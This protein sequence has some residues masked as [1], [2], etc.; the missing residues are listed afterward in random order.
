MLTLTTL[1]E[2]K[3]ENWLATAIDELAADEDLDPE[4]ADYVEADQTYGNGQVVDFGNREYAIYKDYDEAEAAAVE[5]LTDM[6]ES[7]PGVVEGISKNFL[8]S[9][10]SMSP[11][12]QRVYAIDLVGERFSESEMSDQEVVDEADAQEEVDAWVTP[13]D[14]AV[15]EAND[16]YSEGYDDADEDEEE[17][18]SKA[19]DEADDALAKA[20]GDY[21][22]QVASEHREDLESAAIEEIAKELGDDPVGY[23]EDHFGY[24]IGDIIEQG[25][26][27][28]NY[29]ELA[30][31][32]IDSDGVAATLSGYDGNQ[33]DLDSGAVA[34]RTN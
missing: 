18:L 22:A 21:L 3:M 24:S 27:S 33:I 17:R 26:L 34:F 31:G 5:S 4:D 6:L 8:R 7:D 11:T 10:L 12:D 29:G 9:Y 28:L 20:E 25:I 16:L 30:Q 15:E 13:F 2:L 14:E 32:I 23:F 1:S 19:V